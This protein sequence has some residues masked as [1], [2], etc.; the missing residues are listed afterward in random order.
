MMKI[1]SATYAML[2]SHQ[3]SKN[4][5]VSAEDRNLDI[6]S[7]IESYH[8]SFHLMG[9]NLNGDFSSFS[10][11]DMLED[12][13]QKAKLPSEVEL[14][15]AKAFLQR[16][17]KEI[18]ESLYKENLEFIQKAMVA[19]KNIFS[20]KGSQED[21]ELLKNQGGDKILNILKVFSAQSNFAKDELQNAIAKGDLEQ[22]QTGLQHY[23]Q[24]ELEIVGT[25]FFAFA[26]NFEG[27][28]LQEETKTQIMESLSLVHSYYHKS[29]SLNFEGTTIHYESSGIGQN[30]RV[31]FLIAKING[32]EKPS[33]A[34]IL[35]QTQEFYYQTLF[36]TIDNKDNP[37]KE[38][39]AQVSTSDSIMQT[40]LKESKSGNGV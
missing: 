25:K 15:S 37:T 27:L 32:I 21:F 4:I 1:Q 29:T 35:T 6:I 39:Q 38:P 17:M 23:I 24:S 9:I 28:Q 10:F 33:F 14:R 7:Q 16:Q 13:M 2:N 18:V 11:A 31:G 26:L 40:L 12:K 20:Q 3:D 8:H 5:S 36:H 19:E 34:N 22:I 30:A